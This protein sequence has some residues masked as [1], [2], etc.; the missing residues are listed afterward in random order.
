MPLD[1]GAVR[2]ASSVASSKEPGSCRRENFLKDAIR[3]AIVVENDMVLLDINSLRRMILRGGR[4]VA[5]YR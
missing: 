3:L 1:F 5:S 2:R 4:D